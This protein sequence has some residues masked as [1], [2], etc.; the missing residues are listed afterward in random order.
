MN[1]SLCSSSLSTLIFTNNTPVLAVIIVLNDDFNW[2]Q[3]QGRIHLKHKPAAEPR[4]NMQHPKETKAQ[5]CWQKRKPPYDSQHARTSAGR[6]SRRRRVREE[7]SLWVSS[8]TFT[9]TCQVHVQLGV[10]PNVRVKKSYSQVLQVKPSIL[11]VCACVCVACITFLSLLL[12]FA[13]L[14]ALFPSGE[15]TTPNTLIA[16]SQ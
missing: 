13:H 3:Q 5:R 4:E 8:L 7:K 10:E 14:L 1:V 2:Q 12:C 16:C 6:A 15:T 11:C 9:Q